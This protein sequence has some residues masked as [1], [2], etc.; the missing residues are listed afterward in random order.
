[1]TLFT[2]RGL[3]AARRLYEAEGFEL[4]EEKEAHAWGKEMVEQRWDL[5]L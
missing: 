5:T 4:A 1:M 3:D 2:V